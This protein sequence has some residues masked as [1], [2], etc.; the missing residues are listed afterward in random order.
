VSGTPAFVVN[1]IVLT[2]A[3]PLPDFV[4]IIDAELTRLGDPAESS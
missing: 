1:G 4:R 3:R 2:G